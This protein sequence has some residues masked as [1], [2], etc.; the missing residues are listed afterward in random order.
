MHLK[1][2]VELLYTAHRR[3]SSIQVRWTYRYSPAVMQVAQERWQEMMGGGSAVAFL[4]SPSGSNNENTSS[5][6]LQ[7]QMDEVRR[8][9]WWQ[10]PSCWREERT[11]ER[12]SD[13]GY[14]SCD[15]QWWLFSKNHV[16]TNATDIDT[17]R[18]LQA[19]IHVQKSQGTNGMSDPTFSVPLLDPSFL[20]ATH[21]LEPVSETV[22]AGRPAIEVRGT[23]Q[24]R[25]E[26]LHEGFFWATADE[27]RLLVDKEYGILLR[28]AAVIDGEEYAVSSVEEVIYDQP[29]PP[30]TFVFSPPS[31]QGN[32]NSEK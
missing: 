5:G 24:K 2:L 22:H 1:D 26:T 16:T 12:A 8:Q 29:I 4:V 17:E 14:I 30:E 23:W 7:K 9:V 11:W 19:G 6:I 32:Q 15:G 28:Y 25:I 13:N 21:E 10:K 27:Y 20:L 18:W 31:S 3:Y